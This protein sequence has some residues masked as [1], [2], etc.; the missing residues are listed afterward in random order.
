MSVVGVISDTHGLLRKEALEALAGS[1]LILHAGDIGDPTILESLSEIAPVYAVRGNN[2]VAPWA[3]K[4]PRVLELKV[5][6]VVIRLLHDVA[7]FTLDDAP[8]RVLVIGHSHKP[9]VETRDGVLELN[10]GS[11]GPRRFSLPISVAQ[12]AVRGTDV[13][14]HIIMLKVS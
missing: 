9:R 8:P 14:A 3:R 11:A 1:D 12:L 5:D 7:D 4:I 6:Q 10:P 13:N 2:D